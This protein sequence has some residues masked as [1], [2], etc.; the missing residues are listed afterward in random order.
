MIISLT[1]ILHYVHYCHPNLKKSSRYKVVC[2]CECCISAKR[3]DLSLLSWHDRYLKKIRI[4]AKMLK[5]EGMGEKQT[6]YMKHIKIQSCHMGVVF[7]PKHMT[8]QRQKC[9]HNHSQIM[10]YHT[11][12]VY[13]DVVPN[14]QALIFLTSKQMISIP[15]PV[16]QFDFTFIT[17]LRAVQNMAGFR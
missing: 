7:M 9:V 6:A 12:N 16:L 17:W 8:W 2:G 4:S 14:V 5:T 3:I 10:R 15:A 1:V 11:G 13:F